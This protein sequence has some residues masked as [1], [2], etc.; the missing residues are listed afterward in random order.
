MEAFSAQGTCENCNAFTRSV[1]A[2]EDDATLLLHHEHGHDHG[3]A[4][5]GIVTVRP[6]KSAEFVARGS[7]RAVRR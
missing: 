3:H 4:F 1:G 6:A 5:R 7:P 2:T